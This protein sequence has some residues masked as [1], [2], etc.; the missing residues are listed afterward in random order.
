MPVPLKQSQ[1]MII[2]PPVRQKVQ[3]QG[4]ISQ[5]RKHRR[6]KYRTVETLAGP[7]AKYP[8]GRTIYR[9]RTVGKSIQENLN[10]I[11]SIQTRN[12]APLGPCQGLLET[13]G[14]MHISSLPGSRHV[15]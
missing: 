7:L 9:F 14:R 3:D 12:N 5:S 4:G 1:H 10:F 13:F 2:V 11:R 8:Q 6:G 15:W